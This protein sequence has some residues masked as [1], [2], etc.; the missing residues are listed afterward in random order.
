M[1]TLR[2]ELVEAVLESGESLEN[3][4]I[5]TTLTENQLNLK[6]HLDNISKDAPT[7][8]AWSNAHVFF[9][10]EDRGF[11]WISWVS[12]NPEGDTIK[13]SK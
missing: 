1:K 9:V 10:E 2:Q 5:V 6:S 3:N 13:L 4:T 11:Q 7:F 8:C 12:K